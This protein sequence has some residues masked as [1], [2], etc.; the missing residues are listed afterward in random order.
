MALTEAQKDAFNDWMLDLLK[1]PANKAAILAAKP[2]VTFDTP[3]FTT[4]LTAKDTAYAGKEGVVVALK[5]QLA[6][7]NSVANNALNDWY[8]ESSNVAD[9]V[10]GH[11]GKD[12]PLSKLIRDKRDSF[13]HASPTPPT[14]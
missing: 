9:A 7:A 8:K 2:G 5:A 14:P 11:C 12:H 6:T 1:D 10:V 13:S 4:L 3:G